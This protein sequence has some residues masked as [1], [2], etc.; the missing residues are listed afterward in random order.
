MAIPA[1]APVDSPLLLG[2][3]SPVVLGGFVML[4]I[5]G[6]GADEASEMEEVALDSRFL[7]TLF[8]A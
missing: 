6:I 1:V 8:I 7:V 5:V 3:A 2:G 4:A